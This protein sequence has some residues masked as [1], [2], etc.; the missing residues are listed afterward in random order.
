MSK[1]NADYLLVRAQAAG[2]VK[3]DELAVFMGQ[4]HVESAGFS[5]MSEGLN[6]SGRRL[7]QV[8]PGRN[9]MTTLA[10]AEAIAS[11]GAES[12]ANA[13]YGGRWGER[14]LGNTEPGDGW[15]FR[16]RGYVQLSGRANYARIGAQI[17]LDLVNHPELVE[18]REIAATVA[19]HYWQTRV[20]PK[21]AQLDVAEAT[22]QINGGE[23][24]LAERRI[25][26]AR[27]KRK[28]DDGYLPEAVIEPSVSD[29]LANLKDALTRIE[30][31]LL[32]QSTATGRMPDHVPVPTPPPEVAANGEVQEG[33]RGHQVR[34]LQLALNRAGALDDRRVALAIDGI[35]G[36]ETRRAVESF[37]LWS[38]LETTGVVDPQTRRLLDDPAARVVVQVPG[39]AADLALGAGLVPEN[40]SVVRP[41]AAA[42]GSVA[43]V[44]KSP[45]LDPGD[46]AHPD[47]AMYDRI[48][49]GVRAIQ[50]AS[51]KP[52]DEDSERISR[53]LLNR[54]KGAGGDQGGDGTAAP[55]AALR[56]VDHVFMG[57]NGAVIVIEGRLDDPAHRRISMSLADALLLSAEASD[58]RLAAPDALGETRQG[59]EH[60]QLR[61]PA[62]NLGP[63][64]SS[65]PRMA[66]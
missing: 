65:A 1:E 23:N 7:L 24:H 50:E 52:Y 20:V 36:A 43:T 21:G 59:Q 26:A 57:T 31:S 6:Y 30:Q 9:G 12:I 38:G 3:H 18:D 48:R 32:P 22:R 42:V 63:P 29:P 2:I 13:M 19:L 14:N 5:R 62:L 34:E 51:G 35:F 17:G 39:D 53:S 10:E 8:F 64:S 4:M 15:K 54:C 33:A 60:D 41:S 11:G 66:G 44:P 25:H 47:H 55:A 61:L 37:Q 58:H 27:W 16:G 45:V 46:P 28:L 56:R 40:A 49:S